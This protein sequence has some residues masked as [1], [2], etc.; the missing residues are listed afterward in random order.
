MKRVLRFGLFALFCFCDS[1]NYKSSSRLV[2][3]IM[4]A[5]P[6]ICHPTSWN[7]AHSSPRVTDVSMPWLQPGLLHVASC[8]ILNP[9]WFLSPPTHR[10]G[11]GNEVSSGIQTTCYYPIFATCPS[12]EGILARPVAL[13]K[14]LSACM[15]LRGECM[16]HHNMKPPLLAIRNVSISLIVLLESRHISG[17]DNGT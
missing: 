1:V 12:W 5:L 9:E 4:H 13:P 7:I 10:V 11:M 16:L 15:L 14:P 6:R 3:L 8:R 2:P 17:A